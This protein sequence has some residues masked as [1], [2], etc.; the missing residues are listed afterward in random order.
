MSNFIVDAWKLQSSF[1]NILENM[2]I[3]LCCEKIAS[4]M[5]LKVTI[6]DFLVDQR[7]F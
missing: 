1:N 5:N 7:H 2:K 4:I 6:T 3:N